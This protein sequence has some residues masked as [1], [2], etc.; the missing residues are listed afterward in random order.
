MQYNRP[1][2][3]Q[4][5]VDE[6]LFHCFDEMGLFTQGAVV[7]MLYKMGILKLQKKDGKIDIDALFPPMTELELSRSRG[8]GVVLDEAPEPLTKSMGKEEMD[9]LMTSADLA[10]DH[11]CSSSC[12]H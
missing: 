12:N 2:E 1:D 8:A 6:F 10:L 11:Q 9:D 5:D 4:A 3:F 7:F